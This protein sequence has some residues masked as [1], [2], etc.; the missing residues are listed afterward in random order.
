MHVQI[1]VFL[2]VSTCE[3]DESS[4]YRKG[5]KKNHMYEEV[6]E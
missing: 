3:D 2:S 6:M 5:Q 1:Y 4:K